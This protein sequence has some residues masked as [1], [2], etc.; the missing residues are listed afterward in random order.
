MARKPIIRSN[1]FPYHIT[2]RGNNRS[3]FPTNASI[4]WRIFSASLGALNRT[5]GVKVH[6]FVMMPNHFHLIASTPEEELGVVMKHFMQSVTQTVNRNCGQSGRI[7]GSRY[8]GSL[9]DTQSYYDYAMKYVYR[10]PVR[11]SLCTRAQ[12]YQYSSLR[13][14]LGIDPLQFTLSP[15]YDHHSLFPNDNKAEY[16][17][18][19]NEPFHTEYEFRIKHGLKKTLFS[20]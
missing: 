7:F 1:E 12:D 18:W 19:L 6:A 10:N 9:I 3:D 14:L 13:G 17:N 15:A 8:H 5:M 11:A 16:L 4:T 2:G 20:P